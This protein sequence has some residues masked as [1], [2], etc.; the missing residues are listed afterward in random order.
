[1]EV[2]GG[3][4]TSLNLGI[5]QLEE[6]T[7]KLSFSVRSSVGT[8]KEFLAEKLEVLIE[9]MGGTITYEGDYPA[10]E[11]Q[12]ESKIRE[13]FCR[14]YEEM[15]GQKPLVESIHAG[16]E[17]GILSNKLPGLDCISLGPQISGIHTSEEWL[18]VSSTER[19]WKLLLEVLKQ[20]K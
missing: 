16:L 12:S 20:W 6:N 5:L 2:A 13:L 8:A 9:Y 3:V 19:T 11:F 18:S 1:M 17:C 10:W 7:L 15:F 14:T 4:E